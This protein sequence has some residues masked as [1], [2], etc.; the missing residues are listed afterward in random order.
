MTIVPTRPLVVVKQVPAPGCSG[1]ATLLSS[2]CYEREHSDILDTFNRKIIVHFYFNVDLDT[3]FPQN[4]HYIW[5]VN[6]LVKNI[7]LLG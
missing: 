3:S 1:S 4:F 2:I 7:I 5:Y 6:N